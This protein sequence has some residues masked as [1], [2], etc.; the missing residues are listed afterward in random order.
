MRSST[1]TR[2]V[3]LISARTLGLSAVYFIWLIGSHSA[4]PGN[5]FV[6][7]RGVT[8]SWAYPTSAVVMSCSLVMLEALVLWLVMNRGRAPEL[9]K[10]A[11]VCVA[12]T[13]PAALFGG[14]T[15]MHAPPYYNLHF[16]WLLTAA[17]LSSFAFL[18][19]AL[20]HGL[21]WF[22]TSREGSG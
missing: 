11:L 1:G 21:S 18:V 5:Y 6:H 16:L 2:V 8:P 17:G 14:G 19:S 10:R 15:S 3:S 20:G 13:L 12:L 9:W 7:R 22:S 4:N